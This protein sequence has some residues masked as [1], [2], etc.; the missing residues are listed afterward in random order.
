MGL[1]DHVK[2]D[3]PLPIPGANDLEYQT[4]SFPYPYLDQ[5]WI[6]SDGSLWK[7]KYDTEDRSDPSENGWRRYIGMCTRINKEWVPYTATCSMEFHTILPDNGWI[8]WIAL[9]DQGQLVTVQVSEHQVIKEG[10][11]E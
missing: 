7:E 11:H 8:S 6:K 2:C 4:K 3:Y 10:Q 9:F 1:F 5:Y